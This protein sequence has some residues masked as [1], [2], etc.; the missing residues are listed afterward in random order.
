[1]NQTLRIT[2]AGQLESIAA[3]L[4]FIDAACQRARIDSQTCYDMKLAVD[5]ACANIITHGYAGMNPGSIMLE[6]A[7]HP[8]RVILTLTDFGHPFEPYQ[9]EPPKLSDA[10]D[11]KLTS[12]FGLFL[13]YS[14]MDAVDYQATEEGNR[15]ILTKK[16]SKVPA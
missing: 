15:L 7:F 3:F 2:R 8:A 12:G 6:L 9:P 13:I 11:G 14:V 16:L 4:D 5:E 10:L 1:M